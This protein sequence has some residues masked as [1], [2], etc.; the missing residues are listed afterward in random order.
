MKKLNYLFF[1]VCFFA[2]CFSLSANEVIK[3]TWKNDDYYNKTFS[4]VASSGKTYTI[5][6][7]DDSVI[8]TITGTGEWQPINHKYD[9]IN[10]YQVVVEGD[11]VDCLFT[12]FICSNSKL[13][14]LDIKACK[15]LR[16]LYCQNNLL[17]VLDLSENT[18]LFDLKCSNNLLNSISLCENGNLE[19]LNC[20]NN[21]LTELD[22]NTNITLRNLSCN[23][24]QLTT[25]DLTTNTLLWNLSCANNRLTNLNQINTT[26]N[27]LECSNNQLTNINTNMYT[28]LISLGCSSNQLTTLDVSAN[29]ALEHL[30][31]FD[32]QLATLDISANWALGELDCSN[33]RLQLSDLYNASVM[34]VKHPFDV[35][36][37]HLGTQLLAP[38]KLIVNNPV[39]YSTQKEF[40]SIATVFDVLKNG[41]PPHQND[42][43]ILDGIITFYDIAYYTVTM[44]NSAIKSFGTAKVIASFEVGNTGIIDVTQQMPAFTIYPNPTSNILYIKTT[45]EVIPEVKLYSIEGKQ[46]LYLR[47]TEID[48][49][50]Y[51]A[52]IYFVQIEGKTMKL[53]KM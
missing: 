21:L 17:T 41:L 52:G 49:S 11:S 19:V 29:S 25:L 14:T 16:T 2:Y 8:Q 38:Q 35:L 30:F 48:M 13:T 18:E 46:L 33:N 5:D 9:H 39:D 7:G 4:V 23:N 37:V 28:K 51:P 6:W 24:N 3:F 15:A 42:Y 32:N 36:F 50:S 27:F 47:S 44:T 20:D 10:E 31:C 26:L 40:G 1:T 34:L 22:L 45:N 43:T 53:I 12:N